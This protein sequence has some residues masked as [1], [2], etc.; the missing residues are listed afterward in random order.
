MRLTSRQKEEINFLSKYYQKKWFRDFIPTE[1][2][3]IWFIELTSKGVWSKFDR[4][5][6]NRLLLAKRSFDIILKYWI[7]D[8]KNWMLSYRELLED[9]NNDI[10]LERIILNIR[11]NIVPNHSYDWIYE[12]AVNWW[13]NSK[14]A[15]IWE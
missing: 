8:M 4:W 5:E 14:Y 10:Y 2:E 11:K 13:L 6:E 7:E 3:I 12:I 1:R 9:F 15:V